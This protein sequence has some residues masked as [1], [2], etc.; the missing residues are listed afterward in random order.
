MI[1]VKDTVREKHRNNVKLAVVE[2]FKANNQSIVLHS[3]Y[4]PPISTLDPIQQLNSSLDNIHESSCIFLIGDVNLPDW[5]LDY[6]K[7][8]GGLLEGKFCELIGDHFLINI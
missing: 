8:D 7:N 6:P 1:A 3:F 4:R 2:L 5:S